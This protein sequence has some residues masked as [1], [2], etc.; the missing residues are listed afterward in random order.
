MIS[1]K[2]LLN[3]YNINFKA[4]ISYYLKNVM[5]I[6]PCVNYYINSYLMLTHLKL[7]NYQIYCTLIK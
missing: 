7:K 4:I 3:K 5:V 1:N 6:H 2:I